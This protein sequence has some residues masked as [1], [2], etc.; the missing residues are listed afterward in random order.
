MTHNTNPFRSFWMGGYEC[1]DHLNAFGN[2]VDLLHDTG[3]L[4]RLRE[5]Y[6]A[7]KAF[8]IQT[9]REGIRWSIAEPQPYVYDWR[10]VDAIID[11][12][13]EAGTQVVWDICHFG[14]AQDLTP[15][16]P[17]FARRFAHL[18]RAFAQHYRS[19][20]PHGEWIVTPI[21]EVSFLSWLGGD[22]RGTAPYTIHQ[23]WDVKYHLMKAYIE[24]IEALREVDDSVRVLTTEPLIYV[25]PEDPGNPEAVMRA[26]HIHEA[27]FQVLD[28]LSGRMCPELR[29]RPEYLD[30]L[31]FNYYH[32]N[33]WRANE[34]R[35]MLRWHPEEAHPERCTLV[36]LL[37]EAWQRY[38]R[39]IVL[40]ETSHYGEHRPQWLQMVAA[41]CAA[42]LERDFPLWGV[43]LYPILDR[44][45]W[46]FPEQWH[47]SGLW[48]IPDPETGE[49]VLHEPTAEALL[50][51]QQVVAEA[52]EMVIS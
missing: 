32:N 33:Q 44:P 7:L 48:D 31:G 16:H 13:Q 51:A 5:D 38:G 34:S 42:L 14:F 46:D 21:N 27:Q 50:Q 40:S 15:L 6:R 3:H 12:A 37:E 26:A 20:V 45:D 29:G 2:R 43:C 52:M 11:A 36:S 47:R 9:V 49:R 22:V 18:C 39:P 17:M 30:I 24:G 41:E 4:E 19:R 10:A 8:D 28:I 35:E 25:A 23:G 1:A